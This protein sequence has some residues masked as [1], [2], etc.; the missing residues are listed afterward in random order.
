MAG[1]I[2]FEQRILAGSDFNGVAP[3]GTRKIE[4]GFRYWE[5]ADHGGLFEFDIDEPYLLFN[6]ELKLG[7]QDTWTIHK[8]D[9]AGLELLL[10]RGTTESDFYTLEEEAVPI[11]IGQKI[12]VRTDRATTAMVARVYLRL[13]G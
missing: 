13:M 3:T 8:K 7:G 10:W 5:A 1:I 9:T 6:I 2:G 4:R 12:I 11:S